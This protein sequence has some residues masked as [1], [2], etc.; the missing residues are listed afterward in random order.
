MTVNLE[1]ATSASTVAVLGAG[2]WGTTFAKV[3]ADAAIASGVDRR[4]RIWGRRAEVVEQINTLH[5]NEQYLKD[6]VLPSSITASTDVVEVFEGAEL[7]IL[8]VPAQTLRP[9]LREWKHL[10]PPGAFVVSLM[11]GLEL[12]SDAR[13]SQVI[14]EELDIPADRVAVVSGPNLAMEIAREEPTASV[15][16]CSDSEAAGWIARSCTAPYFRPYTTTDV[17]G[18]EIGGIV[19]NVIALA[20]GI[21]EGKRMGDNTKASVI[22]RGLAETSRL[23]LALG[24]EA[25]TMAGLAGLGDLVA[26]CSSPLSRNHTAGRLLGKGLTLEQVTAEMNQTAEGIKSSQAVHELAGKLD[27]EMPITAAVVAVLAGKLSVD[28]LGPLLLSRDLKPEG[29]H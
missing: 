10:L 9:Q 23:T 5:K 21:C 3:V 1:R 27:V 11:K 13:M 4:I 29:D 17:I 20:V 7:V 14:R 25:R 15:V 19:K 2:S 16:A 22:T 6:I 24:G 26:T 8:A 28:E 18:V 12:H